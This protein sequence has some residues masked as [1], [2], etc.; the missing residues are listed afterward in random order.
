MRVL[1]GAAITLAAS[2]KDSTAP[3][4]VVASVVVTPDSAAVGVGSSVQ[5]NASVRD[6]QG[7][8]INGGAVVWTTTDGGKVR[9]STRGSVVGLSV[10]SATVTATAGGRSGSATVRVITPSDFDVVDAQFT[11]AAQ[12]LDG[13]IPMVVGGNGAAVNVLIH[14]D[15]PSSSPMQVVLRLFNAAGVLVRADTQLTVGSLGASP[16]YAAPSVQFTLPASALSAGMKWQVVRDPKGA[17][18]DMDLADDVFPRQSPATLATAA[19]PTLRIKFVPVILTAHGNA[20]GVVTTATLPNY[21]RTLESVHPLG[22][23]E[24]SVDAP[25]ATALS[26]G[27]PRTGG[28]LFAFW[29]PLLAQLDQRRLA[30]PDPSIHYVGVVLPPASFDS[31]ANGG[32]GYIPSF[33]QSTGPGTRTTA[34]I[35][36]GWAF[37]AAFTRETVA[38]ELG[39]NFGRR[40]TP[41]GN[42]PGIDFAYPYAGGIIGLPQFDVRSWVAGRSAAPTLKPAQYGD[43]MGYCSQNWISD[44]TYRAVLQFRGTDAAAAMS[45]QRAPKTRVIIVRGAIANGEIALEP[46]FAIDAH[47]F[48][49][50]RNGSY[51]IEGRGGDGRVLFAHS[52]APAEIDHAPSLRDFAFGIP[53]TAAAEAALTVV[54]VRGPFG[55]A[56]LDRPIAPAALRASSAIAPR[57][58]SG[59]LVSVACADANARGILVLDA[60][61][62][63]FLGTAHGSQASV[64]APAGTPLTVVCTD[65]IQSSRTAVIAP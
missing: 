54:E 52:F 33:G 29:T 6:A 59:G 32:I 57:R 31:V 43:I 30:D 14:V 42:P 20:T 55:S 11:Q 36:D 62:G 19:V 34:V 2:C 51:R 5:L 64:V 44:Y 28:D 18:P 38:H 35:S 4:G 25:M 58:V 10:G 39:H 17:V 1:L 50:E 3:S 15:V 63:A 8:T 41:C 7:K 60:S 56:R 9:V 24:A 47:P 65:G 13:S 46:V 12:A 49:P 37:N 26:F 61:T 27:V 45:A 53:V 22:T 16:S 23:I 40:H 21:L 48:R